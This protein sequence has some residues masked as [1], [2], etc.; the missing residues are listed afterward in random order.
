MRKFDSGATRDADT[1]KHDYE[2]FY[3]PLVMERF[4]AYMHRH[5]VQADG[6]LRDSDNWQKGIPKDAY[7][8]SAFRHFMDWWNNTE[9]MLGKMTWK[10]PSALSYSMYRV[11]SLKF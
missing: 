6:N 10:N 7:I 2:G 1:N 8:K 3:S 11:I 5:R 9:D 4:G